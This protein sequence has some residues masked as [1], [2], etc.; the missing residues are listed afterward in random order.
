M[1]G[2]ADVKIRARSLPHIEDERL[3][4]RLEGLRRLLALGAFPGSR[5]QFGFK[6]NEAAYIE[7]EMRR[8][9]LDFAPVTR[10]VI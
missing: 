8:R 7:D 9:G 3:A 5:M 10:R 4:A 6:A 2:L 1:N